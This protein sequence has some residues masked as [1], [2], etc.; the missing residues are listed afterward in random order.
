MAKYKGTVAITGPISP[1]DTLDM[2]ATHLASFGQGGYRSASTIIER[3]AI[4]PL[5]R[6]VGMVVYVIENQKEYRLVGG[7]ANT[8]WSEV[9]SSGGSSN[10]DYKIVNNLTDRDNISLNDRKIGSIVYVVSDNT[11][12]RLVNGT[13]NTDW[14][15]L[16]NSTVENYKILDSF[17]TMEALPASDRKIGLTVYLSDTDEEYRLVGGTA[18]PNW[19]KL[20]SSTGGP[21]ISG[22]SGYYQIVKTLND[23]E[24]YPML[25]RVK[26]L[27]IYVS[28]VDQEYRLMKGT[29]NLNW[30]LISDPVVINVGNTTT[31]VN[32]DGST[33]TIN[34]YNYTT[35]NYYENKVGC[36]N[37]A[38][39]L[40]T[41]I[42]TS[43]NIANYNDPI[44]G[45]QIISI[46]DAS[47][48]SFNIGSDSYWI[49]DS[50]SFTGSTEMVLN[51]VCKSYISITENGITDV[52]IVNDL[53]LSSSTDPRFEIYGSN[54]S[55]NGY[56][57]FSSFGQ[58]DIKIWEE[59]DGIKSYSINKT[60]YIFAP[61]FV[62]KDGESTTPTDIIEVP[63]NPFISKEY[64]IDLPENSNILI[65]LVKV[66][67]AS[68]GINT[69][70]FQPVPNTSGILTT[71][72]IYK[73]NFANIRE[74]LVDS[75]YALLINGTENGVT[76]PPYFFGP[77][78][79]DLL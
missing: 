62:I 51:R 39:I 49:D 45:E 67:V 17:T 18:N 69:N 44:T 65:S 30:V 2:Y 41:I 20:S 3:D 68:R 53:L 1:T 26:G 36:L 70:M 55:W 46:E 4:L 32:P 66:N 21:N 5:R 72:G 10:G 29:E 79:I 25:D 16:E 38:L 50:I 8:N 52:F 9:V 37:K 42:E 75:T 35:N 47:S 24:N 31:V 54:T 19:V 40:E 14:K 77:F 63:N 60:L 6:E 11:E 76:L 43:K 58:K 73:I 7:T 48:F 12:Y 78:I 13:S 23:L 61:N 74:N 56:F 34:E 28:D 59:F 57:K 27:T 71:S 15:A 22:T 64:N 33:S